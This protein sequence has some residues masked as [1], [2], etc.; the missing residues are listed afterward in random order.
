[1]GRATRSQPFSI[2]CRGALLLCCA[3]LAVAW[4]NGSRSRAP[5]AILVLAGG[6]GIHGRPHETVLRRL[7]E[8]AAV[9]REAAAAGH[10]PVIV[11][12]GGGTTHKPKWV[13]AAGYAVPE[14]VLMAQELQQRHG[15]PA[16]HVYAEGY[17]DDTVGNAFFA[18]AM[19]V[20]PAGWRTL[21]VVTSAFQMAR[22][23]AI[24]DWIFT[25][26]SADGRAAPPRELRYVEVDDVGA[27]APRV[28]RSRRV[29]E[30]GALEGFRSDVAAR[31]RTLE[32]VHSWINTQHSAY[33]F[34]GFAK[35][36]PLNVSSALAQTY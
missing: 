1:M 13:N 5:D 4:V 36:K 12:N 8:A 27:L 17:S 22:T 29:K 15:V 6:V 2:G 18:R 28:L 16:E 14:A 26:P 20:D 30:A 24:Y 31:L 11:C 32:A 33:S 19:H 7:R 34:T 3:L 25:L 21:V 10:A 23:R 9:Y 35:K